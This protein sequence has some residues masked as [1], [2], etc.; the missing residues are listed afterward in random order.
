VDK[1]AHTVQLNLFLLDVSMQTQ[2]TLLEEKFGL[3]KLL[4]KSFLY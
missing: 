3:A 2:F 1:Q 4:Q